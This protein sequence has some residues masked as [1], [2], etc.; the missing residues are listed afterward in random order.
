MIGDDLGEQR[1][2]VGGRGY[3]AFHQRSP[4]K[5]RRRGERRC[6]R[7]RPTKL[8]GEGGDARRDRAAALVP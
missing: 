2:R 7:A 8:S 4:M 6:E 1:E 3:L 5:V